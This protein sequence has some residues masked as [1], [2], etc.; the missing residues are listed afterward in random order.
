MLRSGLGMALL[1]RKIG[2][3]SVDFSC[4]LWENEGG[5]KEMLWEP[6]QSLCFSRE[7]I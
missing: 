1:R 2:I 4:R 5:D 6:A 3:A 7:G